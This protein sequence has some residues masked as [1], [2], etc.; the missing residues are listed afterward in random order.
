MQTFLIKVR[1][2]RDKAALVAGKDSGRDAPFFGY[3]VALCLKKGK[4]CI[5]RT[6]THGK[7]N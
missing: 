1:Q 6:C 4:F 7:L 5:L 3:W 2:V